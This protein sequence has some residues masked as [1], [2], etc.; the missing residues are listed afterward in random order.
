[1]NDKVAKLK[2]LL[3][4]LLEHNLEHVREHRKW[5]ELCEEAGLD[6]IAEDLKQVVSHLEAC[7][8][9]FESAVEKIEKL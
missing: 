2:H 9:Y 6:D 1:M 3:P 5:V 7:T 8:P 4:H